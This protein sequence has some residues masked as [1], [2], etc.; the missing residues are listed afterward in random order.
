MDNNTLLNHIK[1]A[2][3][4][5]KDFLTALLV[6]AGVAIN[7]V[8]QD[9]KP[10][11]IP[12][13]GQ[14]METGGSIL[15]AFRGNGRV[16]QEH[17]Q[18]YYQILK[19]ADEYSNNSEFMKALK[20]AID[21]T[22]SVDDLGYNDTDIHGNTYESGNK[23][24]NTFA[25]QSGL[26]SK[27]NEQHIKQNSLKTNENLEF[28]IQN[29]KYVINY[30]HSPDEKP[31]YGYSINIKNRYDITVLE[32]YLKILHIYDI[33]GRDKKL[34]L[35]IYPDDPQRFGQFNNLFK[36]NINELTSIYSLEFYHNYENIFVAVD[37][38]IES[39]VADNKLYLY[40]RGKIVKE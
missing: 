17:R 26:I 19:K 14:S 24:N 37:H 30:N 21:S 23:L 22:Y 33:N 16:S 25:S 35:I 6:G 1:S 11:N 40:F 10:R 5:V 3:K 36:Q 15:E 39:K 12:E 28:I 27:L 13:V 9:T 31:V 38:F 4:E 2:P 7:N 18:R 34:E 29:K 8:E 32:T 20:T